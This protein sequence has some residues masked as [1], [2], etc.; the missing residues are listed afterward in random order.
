MILKK[1]LWIWLEEYYETQ[2]Q[3]KVGGLHL[4]LRELA[5]VRLHQSSLSPTGETDPDER[6]NDNLEK[7]GRQSLDLE[8][9]GQKFWSRSTQNIGLS[10]TDSASGDFMKLGVKWIFSLLSV[11]IY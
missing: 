6:K 3:S 9:H 10:S 8:R 1:M 11:E 5:S 7:D 2:D 4:D